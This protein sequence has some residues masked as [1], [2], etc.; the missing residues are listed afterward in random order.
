[1]LRS[2]Y[3]QKECTNAYLLVPAKKFMN[4]EVVFQLVTA[5]KPISWILMMMMMMMIW[6]GHSNTSEA[7]PIPILSEIV[8]NTW[9]PKVIK[10]GTKVLNRSKMV[11]ILNSFALISLKN[12]FNFIFGIFCIY[13]FFSI[14]F[15]AR[16]CIYVI[17]AIQ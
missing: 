14:Y 13:L 6:V 4:W 2:W 16:D 9:K 8:H 5:A 10:H 3:W 7:P 1:M 17:F 12:D 11:V 15:I